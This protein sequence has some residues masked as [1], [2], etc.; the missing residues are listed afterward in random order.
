VQEP[1]TFQ[2]LEQCYRNVQNK[3]LKGGKMI[4][5]SSRKM[6]QIVFNE[7]CDEDAMFVEKL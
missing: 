4:V 1:E 6:N 3:W 7:V 2:Y 5:E